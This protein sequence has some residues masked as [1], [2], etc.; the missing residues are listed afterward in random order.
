MLKVQLMNGSEVTVRVQYELLDSCK[1]PCVAIV[2]HTIIIVFAN[3]KY[4]LV[5]TQWHTFIIMRIAFAI[6][7]EITGRKQK[8]VQIYIGNTAWGRCLAPFSWMFTDH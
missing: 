8:T 1:I 7:L 5:A 6:K 4:H 3:A 2:Y